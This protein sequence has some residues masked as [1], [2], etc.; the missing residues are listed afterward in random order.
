MSRKRSG[1]PAL[2]AVSIE[3]S[4]LA[5]TNYEVRGRYREHSSSVEECLTPD[6]EVAGSSLTGVAALCP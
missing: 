2:T 5:H 3:P 6:R 4:V 1:E